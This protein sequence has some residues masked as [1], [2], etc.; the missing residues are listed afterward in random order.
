MSIVFVILAWTG[1]ALAALSVVGWAVTF[2]ST[3]ATLCLLGLHWHQPAS[4][5]RS[6]AEMSALE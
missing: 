2:G 5:S 4:F 1:L 6:S 3:V